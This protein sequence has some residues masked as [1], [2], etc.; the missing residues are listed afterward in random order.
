MRR[1]NIY[2]ERE[3]TLENKSR[4]T[5]IGIYIEGQKWERERERERKKEG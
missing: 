2:K 4:G 1:K 3:K 5:Q